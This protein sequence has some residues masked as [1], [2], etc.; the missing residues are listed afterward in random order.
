MLKVYQ[1]HLNKKAIISLHRSRV[2]QSAIACNRWV[3]EFLPNAP[4][5]KTALMNWASS[6]EIQCQVR[7]YFSSIENAVSFA[8]QNN[9]NYQV[10]PERHAQHTNVRSYAANFIS[11]NAF[12][13]PKTK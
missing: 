2:V 3:L 13:E 5:R 1:M 8:C 12:H 11:R 6:G 4:E 9:I 7:L 10:M